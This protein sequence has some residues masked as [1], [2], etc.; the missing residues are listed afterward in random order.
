MW[1]HHLAA[2]S[3]RKKERQTNAKTMSKETWTQIR[4][5]LKRPHAALPT[6]LV[7][8]ADFLL[9]S[10]SCYLASTRNLLGWF[11]SQVLLLLALTHLYVIHHELVHGSVFQTKR[12]N[13]L[14]GHLV[15]F[16]IGLP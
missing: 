9:V 5:E 12:G 14:A 7:L 2:H 3:L 10:G 1:G 13:E 8:L 4:S 15:S 6:L 11:G 16:L